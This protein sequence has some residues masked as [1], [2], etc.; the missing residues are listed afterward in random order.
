MVWTTSQP[1]TDGTYF[2]RFITLIQV[3]INIIDIKSFLNM[4]NNNQVSD[5]DLIFHLKNVILEMK[6]K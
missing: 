1:Y 6:Y 5:L 2:P 4:N 3:R